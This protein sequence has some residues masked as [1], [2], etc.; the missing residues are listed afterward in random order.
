MNKII[1]YLCI[2]M[3][4]I[5]GCN[6]SNSVFSLPTE[7]YADA[8]LE[9]YNEKFESTYDLNI[10]YSNNKYKIIVNKSDDVKWCIVN[11]GVNCI[12]KNEKFKKDDIF[13]ENIS[14]NQ[15]IIDLDL[16][17]FNGMNNDNAKFYLNEYKY[18]LD[19]DSDNELPKSITIFSNDKIVKKIF[20][21]LF[22]EKKIDSEH[23]ITLE[24]ILVE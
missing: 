12:I 13:I 11:D 15:L 17:K 23:F 9:V 22:Q 16:S 24:N 14:L 2:L 5:T 8:V 3:I 18:L 6:K 10:F 21:K 19:L 20:F 4:L 1:V 7:Y